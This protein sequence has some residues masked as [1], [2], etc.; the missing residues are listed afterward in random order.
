MTHDKI[1]YI[2]N[3]TAIINTD[4]QLQYNYNIIFRKD[5]IEIW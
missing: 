4:T 5:A 2:N 1:V 3:D